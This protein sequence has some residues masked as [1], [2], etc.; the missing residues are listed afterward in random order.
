MVGQLTDGKPNDDVIDILGFLTFEMVQT[1]TEE[2][3]KVKQMEDRHRERHGEDNKK[4]RKRKLLELEEDDDVVD[5][6][7]DRGADDDKDKDDKADKEEDDDYNEEDEEDDK[8]EK[9]DDD[10]GNA[11][12]DDDQKKKK[13]KRDR[14]DKKMEGL[15][16]NYDP[17]RTPLLPGHIHEAY[18]LLKNRQSARL[19]PMNIFSRRMVRMRLPLI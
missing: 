17:D 11:A 16:K 19:K 3:L 10:K 13:K 4:P 5:D 8:N 14:R 1:I 2:A 12:K 9:D 18:R 7:A 6:D 15:F